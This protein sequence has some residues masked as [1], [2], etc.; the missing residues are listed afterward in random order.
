M[1][2][3]R[4]TKRLLWDNDRLAAELTR[5]VKDPSTASTSPVRSIS[6]LDENTLQFEVQ[7]TVDE[8]I[9]EDEAEAEEEEGEEEQER[10]RPS[11]PRTRKK[12]FHF[13][14][15][16]N[17]QVLTEVEDYEEPRGH[18]GWAS[19]SPD[20]SK[21]VFSRECNLYTM[22]WDD[23]MNIVQARYKKTGEKADSAEAGVEVDETQL[24][25]DGE[26]YYCYGSSGRG[27]T[28][29]EKEK[30]W[31]KRTGCRRH[32]VPRLP[33][34]RPDQAGFPGS[35]GPLGRPRRGKRPGRSS[36]PTSMPCP[37]RKTSGSW[38]SRST[39]LSPGR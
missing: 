35:G 18:V 5:I 20:S 13:E 29:D 37:E 31:G 3:A 6:F 4:G 7:S 27:Q 17:T 14:Y 22:G 32:L 12:V 1:D 36:R 38:S 33:L 16:V 10:A 39:T 11:R 24:T 34:F 30:Q 26:K 23:Y 15:N 21:V 25:T 8:E 2:P 28:D 19:V 9:P